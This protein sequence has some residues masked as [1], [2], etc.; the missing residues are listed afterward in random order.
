MVEQQ[1]QESLALYNEIEDSWGMANSLDGMAEVAHGLGRHGEARRSYQASLTISR[2]MGHP[3]RTARALVGLA[4]VANAFGEHGE[5]DGPSIDNEIRIEN[6]G[7]ISQAS[8]QKK[9]TAPSRGQILYE[10]SLYGDSFFA[11]SAIRL[12]LLIA[13]I[14]GVT[15]TILP[16][17][18]DF[19]G[20]SWIY[21]GI[22][23][24][25][26]IVTGL[27]IKRYLSAKTLV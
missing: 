10:K 1:F 3:R 7:E 26:P 27:A 17:L 11:K 8:G 12:I 21:L 6:M 25:P 4:D 14:W 23:L 16:L 15:F 13:L 24:I 20:P 9:V 18:I 22:C 19:Y 5:A 2:E